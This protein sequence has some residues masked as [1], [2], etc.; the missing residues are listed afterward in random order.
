MGEYGTGSDLQRAAQAVTAALQG[1]AGGNVAGAIGGA[2]APYL[3]QTIKQVAREN[4]AARL[5]AHA[6]LGAVV[7]QA[8]GNSAAA[9]GLGALTAEVAADLIAKQ[10]YEVTDV[11]KLT[12]EQKQ[13][14]SA[15]ATL[16]GGLAGAVGGSGAADAVAGAQGGKNAVENNFLAPDGIPPGLKQMG[17]AQLTLGLHLIENG[18]TNE[19][20]VKAAR[21]LAGGKG[22]EYV[23]PAK[24]LFKSW[25]ALM[26]TGATFGQWT[27]V[28]GVSLLTGS[29]VGGTAN[30]A[31]QYGV[32]NEP[33][34][35]TDLGVAVVTGG[36][37]PGKGV[38]GTVLLNMGGLMLAV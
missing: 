30:V 33:F 32:S 6:V 29:F 38:G 25:F 5:M 17:T 4:E 22:G 13:T 10:L 28:G 9:G 8:Q 23:D 37:S 34:N 18:A 20:I 19:E 36:L 35:Y 31:Y 26:T 11:S 2:A 16:A 14:V 21:D 12:E 7:A 1:L 15:L 24:A 3:A 27:A